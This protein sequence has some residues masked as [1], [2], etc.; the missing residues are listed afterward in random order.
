MDKFL[1][2]SLGNLKDYR[3]TEDLEYSYL[4]DRASEKLD[5]SERL[6]YTA[7]FAISVYSAT[8]KRTTKPFNPLLGETFEFVRRADLGWRSLTEQ[9]IYHE[10]EQSKDSVGELKKSLDN[11]VALLKQLITAKSSLSPLNLSV[12]GGVSNDLNMSGN[13]SDRNF[14][15]LNGPEG[16]D[17]GGDQVERSMVPSL[18]SEIEASEPVDELVNLERKASMPAPRQRMRSRT[19]GRQSARLTG[20]SATNP[21]YN[22]TSSIQITEKI[23]ERNST[24]FAEFEPYFASNSNKMVTPTDK[25]SKQIVETNKLIKNNKRLLSGA[26]GELRNTL[27][28][29]ADR[30]SDQKIRLIRIHRQLINK[31]GIGINQLNEEVVSKL[32]KM[33][34]RGS[35]FY[36]TETKNSSD[37][38]SNGNGHKTGKNS[39]NQNIE[40]SGWLYKWTNYVKGYR[41]RWFLIDSVGNLKYYR[42]S[43]DVN[44][45]SRGSIKMEEA[46]VRSD[47]HD[48]LN[49]IITVPFSQNLHLRAINDLDRSKWLKALENAKH[50]AI[51]RVFSLEDDENETEKL[52]TN[53]VEGFLHFV[54]GHLNA[55][56]AKKCVARANS[57]KILRDG[58]LK[59]TDQ[60]LSKYKKECESLCRLAHSQNEKHQEL[61]RQYEILARQHQQLEGEALRL[62]ARVADESSKNTGGSLSYMTA[63]GG[64]TPPLL[65]NEAE[66]EED[67]F[68]DATDTLPEEGKNNK[69]DFF[70]ENFEGG[71]K[72]SEGNGGGGGGGGGWSE[73]SSSFCFDEEEIEMVNKVGNVVANNSSIITKNKLNEVVGNSSL[74]SQ[75]NNLDLSKCK[76]ILPV[77]FNEPL[78]MLQRITEDLE[79]SY[80]LDR[81]SEKLDISERL[82]YTA[83][84]AISVYSATAKRTTKPFNPLL[85]ETFEFDRRADLGWRSITEQVSHHPPAAAMHTEGVNW[86]L[87]QEFMVASRFRGKYMSVIPTGYTQI[88]FKDGKAN[89]IFQK[90]TTTVH[91]IIVGRLWIDN[92]GTMVRE[93]KDKSKLLIIGIEKFYLIIKVVLK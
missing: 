10:L 48:G 12:G 15:P 80:L 78:S 2:D 42:N 27:L 34:K 24:Y 83:A 85:G 8:A 29:E 36:L 63:L 67:Q 81:A 57:V 30:L 76:I 28:A 17:A 46:S 73:K 37:S 79:Y 61:Q 87:S 41:K 20:V 91:N 11:K 4:L 49:M 60:L 21:L 58:T 45:P 64:P 89:F 14:I 39:T 22:T 72:G 68:Q 23:K 26:T 82:A 47:Q 50:F 92:H 53:E 55:A 44:G 75:N 93:F 74:K 62:S 77:N 3:I 52:L 71:D 32:R 54:V 65:K 35:S 31:N 66:E 5:I 38:S 88:K 33:P 70:E 51:K 18:W 40:F 16:E 90:V 69:F 1:I 6:A 43:S 56:D 59:L 25:I 13:S 9:G 86:E 7:A 19:A 84:F